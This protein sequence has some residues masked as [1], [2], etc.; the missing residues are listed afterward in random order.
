[1]K[2]LHDILGLVVGAMVLS[3]LDLKSGLHQILLSESSRDYTTFVWPFGENIVSLPRP[4]LKTSP[5]VFQT[6]INE[7]LGKGNNFDFMYIDDILIFSK[8]VDQHLVH[9]RGT[10][11]T[12][13]RAGFNIKPPKCQWGLQ[14]LEY[15]GHWIRNS[16]VAV[17]EHQQLMVQFK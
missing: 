12:L 14:P 6:L 13:R 8:S 17:P 9:I 3:K 1:M 11:I 5:A 2:Q 7:A 16:T 10:L 4:V 15:L